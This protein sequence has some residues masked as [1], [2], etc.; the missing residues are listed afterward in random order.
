MIELEEIKT[1]LVSIEIC[2]ILKN[3]IE[4]TKSS[5]PHKNTN[6]SIQAPQNLYFVKANE[7]LINVFENILLNAIR[8]NTNLNF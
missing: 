8:H 3:A 4:F 6:I 5:Y 7:L 2:K 1:P